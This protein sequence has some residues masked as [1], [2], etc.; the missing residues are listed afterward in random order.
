M[1]VP[2][3]ELLHL[4]GVYGTVVE[5]KVHYEK[6][7]ITT[8]T[9]QGVLTSPTRYV[10]MQCQCQFQQLLLVGRSLAWRSRQENYCNSCWPEA[11][12]FQLLT[13]SSIRLQGSRKWKSMCQN[14]YG[15][16]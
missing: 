7:R 16:S 14:W 10:L 13:H 3:E 15:E 5:N 2:D 1:Y 9:K 11:A 8:S 12:M 4:A 6:L